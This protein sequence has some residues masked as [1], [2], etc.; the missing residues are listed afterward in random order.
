MSF[1][2]IGQAARAP[3]PAPVD[4]APPTTTVTTSPDLNQ[5]GWSTA[6]VTLDLTASD[7]I[8]G[9]RE[10]HVQLHDRAGLTADHA[11]IQ[12]GT[13]ATITLATEGD[14]AIGYFAV[15]LLGNREPARTVLVGVDA[16][17]P[18]V[19]G[20]P[21]EPCVIWPPN[22]R[23]ATV[24]DVV[25]ADALSGLAGL[26]VE[27][28]ADEAIAG[29]VLV[30]GGSVQVRATRD[31]KGDGR[32]YTLTATVTDIAGNTHRR[33]GRLHGAARPARRAR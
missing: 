33:G 4:T 10:I 19:S 25:G 16:T 15:D 14:Y 22:G 13:H 8:V 5:A 32:V 7:D 2:G 20:L 21:A 17:S 30:D 31:G 3:Y 28:T 24:A 29:D 1:T 18:T 9:V 12:P 11:F 26:V 27:V 6:P 23:M